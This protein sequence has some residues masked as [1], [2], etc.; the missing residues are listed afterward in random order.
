[1]AA[2][3]NRSGSRCS[4]PEWPFAGTEL[5]TCREELGFDRAQRPNTAAARTHSLFNQK[6]VL[7]SADYNL[8]N[9]AD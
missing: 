5:G 6:D 7:F 3:R 2:R 4:S 1:L 8:T 9:M